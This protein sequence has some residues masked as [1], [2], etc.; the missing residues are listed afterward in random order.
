ML[1]EGKYI[2]DLKSLGIDRSSDV[3]AIIIIIPGETVLIKID[4]DSGFR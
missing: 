1:Q 2:V 4:L 3:P